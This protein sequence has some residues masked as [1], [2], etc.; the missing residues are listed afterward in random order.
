MG[1]GPSG[2]GSVR[3][4]RFDAAAAVGGPRGVLE[5]VGPT[6]LF[7]IALVVRPGALGLALGAALAVSAIAVLARALRHE[8]LTQA[9]GGAVV[10][11][12]SAAWAWKTGTASGF[13]LTGI[14][15]NAV[16]LLACAGSALAGWPLMGLVMGA[17]DAAVEED[18]SR[19]AQGGPAAHAWRAWHDEPSRAQDRRRYAVGTWVLAAM[20][21]LRLAV[22]LPLFL[23]G[24]GSAQALGVAR[25]VLGLP[26]FLATLYL[27][28]LIVR[29]APPAQD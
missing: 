29:P 18:G 5:G 27:V 14:L 9:V 19:S 8:P 13:Y 25:L 21:A 24:A 3:A 7:V 26:L 2:L 15:I 4:G 1:A 6:L 20:F 17:R 28:W 22:E 12:V 16:W 11:A 23:A 10:V